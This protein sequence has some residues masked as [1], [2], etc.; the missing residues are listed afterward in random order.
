MLRRP[1]PH[2][3]DC[4]QADVSVQPVPE[5]DAAGRLPRGDQQPEPYDRWE[6][7]GAERTELLEFVENNGIDNVAFL[8]TDNH[9]TLQNEVSVDNFSDPTPILN[10]TITGPIA[11]NTFQNEVIQVAGPLGLFVF[12]I[13]L[14]LDNIN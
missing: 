11:T 13:V 2:A 12:N 1:R 5:P 3:P 14:N 7:Y 9:G 8:T 6:G 10:E 4:D